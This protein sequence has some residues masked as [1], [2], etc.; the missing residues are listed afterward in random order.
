MA[1]T[2]K[3][4]VRTTV[5]TAHLEKALDERTLR[6]KNQDKI[7]L[8]FQK[9]QEKYNLAIIKLVKA[10]KGIITEASKLNRYYE[11]PKN[12]KK[13]TVPFSITVEL[14]ANGLP[15][16]PEEIEEYHEHR[17]KSDKEAIS[18]AIRVLKMTE[19]EFVSASTYQSVAKYL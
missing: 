2:L 19:D 18:Q 14:N 1:D 6:F 12:K 15:K 10:G 11:Y 7:A 3:V 8:E 13:N 17:Y 5:L 4:R 16:E 9:E